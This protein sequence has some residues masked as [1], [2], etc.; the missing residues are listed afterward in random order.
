[1]EDFTFPEFIFEQI[2]SET[3]NLSSVDKF[4]YVGMGDGMLLA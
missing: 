1:M 4:Y 2:I 3:L